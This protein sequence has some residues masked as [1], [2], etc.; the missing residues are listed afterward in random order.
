MTKIDANVSTRTVTF[1]AVFLAPEMEGPSGLSSYIETTGGDPSFDALSYLGESGRE[2]LEAIRR[3][4]GA[5]EDSITAG[6]AAF[7]QESLANSIEIAITSI[8]E[9][10]TPRG[11]SG[12][13]VRTAYES[14]KRSLEAL[15]TQD[16]DFHGFGFKAVKQVSADVQTAVSKAMERASGLG[17][18]SVP[19]IPVGRIFPTP[20]SMA[21]GLAAVLVIVENLVDGSRYTVPL[22]TLRAQEPMSERDKQRALGLLPGENPNGEVTIGP[23]GKAAR[24]REYLTGNSSRVDIKASREATEKARAEFNRR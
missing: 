12:A 4:Q 21:A 7:D 23:R 11:V 14:L 10:N 8:L 16:D 20:A 22:A 24:V 1:P 3:I 2:N 15:K 19:V 18:H 5:V 6:G 9:L 17:A 13:V